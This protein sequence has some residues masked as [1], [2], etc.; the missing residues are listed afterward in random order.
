MLIYHNFLH[1]PTLEDAMQGRKSARRLAIDDHTRATLAGGLRRHQTPV[2][3][4]K[5]ARA[6][7]L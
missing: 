5:R 7:L 6:I 3:L 1:H 4:A 2:G